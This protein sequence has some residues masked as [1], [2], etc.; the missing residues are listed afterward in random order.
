[1]IQV[2]KI[3]KK[4]Y[5]PLSTDTIFNFSSSSRLRSHNHKISKQYVNKSKYANFFSNRVINEWNNL[6]D[7]IVNAKTINE[8]KNLYDNHTVD[9]HFKINII[10][11]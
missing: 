2:F 4:F 10:T 5:D 1:M 3:A 6:P 7:Y 8:F 9:S 11:D